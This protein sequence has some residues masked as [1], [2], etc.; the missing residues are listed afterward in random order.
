MSGAMRKMGVYLGLLEDTDRYDDEYFEAG[1]QDTGQ[2]P[3]AREARQRLDER[4][5]ERRRSACRAR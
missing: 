3:R 5:R 1:E 4:G 2:E